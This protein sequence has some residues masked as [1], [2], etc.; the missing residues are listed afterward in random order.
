MRQGAGGSC[1]LVAE[2][3]HAD[4]GISFT[5]L[6]FVNFFNFFCSKTNYGAA[7]HYYKE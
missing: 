5:P 7:R 4:Y 3:K 2:Q 6:L 1:W